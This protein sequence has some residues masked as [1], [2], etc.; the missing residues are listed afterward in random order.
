MSETKRKYPLVCLAGSM[1]NYDRIR[2]TALELNM[3]NKIPIYP[4]KW[5]PEIITSE[6]RNKLHELQ[7][8]RIK[9]CDY[10]Y[11]I[12]PDDGRIGDDTRKE[13]LYA[14]Y[15]SK[16]I[17]Y[18]TYP[19]K[20]YTVTLCGSRKFAGAFARVYEQLSL[21]GYIVHLPVTNLM[22]S[23][24]VDRFT[25]KQHQM[26]DYVHQSKMMESDE[27]IIINPGGYIGEDTQKE[28]DF[29][30]S[31][32]MKITFIDDLIETFKEEEDSDE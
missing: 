19:S 14:A 22:T 20:A 30:R 3:A 11:V 28:I 18:L 16:P 26:L 6:I 31:K 29:A 7:K 1:T 21:A 15:I 5:N 12:N 4:I 32:N 27:I 8:E 2:T 25:E 13:I 23:E 9:M 10:L 24:D 17:E